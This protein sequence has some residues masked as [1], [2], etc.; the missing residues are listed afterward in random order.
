MAQRPAGGYHRAMSSHITPL[1]R[2]FALAKTGEYPGISELRI[3]LK[4]EGYSTVQL[5]GPSLLRQLRAI[6]QAARPPSE[7]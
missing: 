2:A 7:A 1:E 6:C 5:E 4:A 3:Q